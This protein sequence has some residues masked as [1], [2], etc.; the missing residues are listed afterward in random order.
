MWHVSS[1]SDVATLRTAI[2]LLLT[3]LQHDVTRRGAAWKCEIESHTD[4]HLA[5]YGIVLSC[6][7]V[8]QLERPVNTGVKPSTFDSD[9]AR[10]TAGASSRVVIGSHRFF[11]SYRFIS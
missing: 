1:R 10:V 2:H 7:E 6:L 9:A 3:Y 5:S 4:T 11:R 8:W